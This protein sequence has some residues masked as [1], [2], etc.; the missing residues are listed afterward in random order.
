[1][2]PDLP[3]SDSHTAGETRRQRLSSALRANL[4]RRKKQAAAR[5]RAGAGAACEEAARRGPVELGAD[6]PH[7]S[8]E[9]VREKTSG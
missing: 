3:N 1:M 7:D 9:I 6:P 4:L 2:K 5:S 8:A